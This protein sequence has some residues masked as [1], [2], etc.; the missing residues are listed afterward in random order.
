VGLYSYWVSGHAGVRG[1]ETAD[2]LARC[3]S[4]LGLTGPEPALGVSRQD[5][6]NKISRWLGNQHLEALA[7]SWQYPKAGS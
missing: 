3:G 1:N 7:K 4:A 2:E 5:L 6:S